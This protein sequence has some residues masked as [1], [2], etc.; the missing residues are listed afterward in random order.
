MRHRGKES[1][2]M[3][4]TACFEP[5]KDP[6]ADKGAEIPNHR[7]MIVSIVPGILVIII[8]FKKVGQT[9]L[10]NGTAPEDPAVNKKKFSRKTIAKMSLLITMNRC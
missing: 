2:K 7:R 1:L 5:K 3:I 10:P 9:N 8:Y 6:I 4:H